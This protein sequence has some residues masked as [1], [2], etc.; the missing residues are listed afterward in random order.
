L[1][2]AG[3]STASS[4]VDFRSKICHVHLPMCVGGSQ[5]HPT[6]PDTSKLLQ[7]MR[8]DGAYVQYWLKPDTYAAGLSIIFNMCTLAQRCR[9]EGRESDA[10]WFWTTRTTACL[11]FFPEVQPFFPSRPEFEVFC[12]KDSRPSPV[13]GGRGPKHSSRPPSTIGLTS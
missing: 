6:Q 13:R 9:A 8:S 1:E 4:V 5:S 2:W 11:S 12:Q 7:I 3:Q 10:R